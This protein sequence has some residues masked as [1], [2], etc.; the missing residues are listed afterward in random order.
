MHLVQINDPSAHRRPSVYATGVTGQQKNQMND[1]H[2]HDGLAKRISQ[3]LRADE[4]YLMF[5]GAYQVGTGQLSHVEAQVRWMHPDYGL[6]LPGVFMPQLEQSD[7]AYEMSCFMIARA[8]RELSVCLSQGLTP[9][10]VSIGVQASA[11]MHERFAEDIRDIALFY[12]VAPNLL[13]LELPE[14]EDAARVLSIRALTADLRDLGVGISYGDFGAGRASLASLGALD[15][16]T[17]KLARELVATVPKDT[18]SCK[19]VEGLLALLESL[20]IR[21]VVDGVETEEQAR[22]LRQWPRIMARGAHWP[23]PVR[24]LSELMPPVSSL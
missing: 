3:G 23:R 18:R 10:P 24:A 2:V 13:E 8:C 17:V 5:R 1:V 19:V 15:I 12:D 22:W 6:L 20:D 7:V 9:C 11:A 21:V 4:F 14:S 16:D